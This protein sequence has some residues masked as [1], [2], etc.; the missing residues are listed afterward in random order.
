[1]LYED[2]KHC[3]LKLIKTGSKQ[4][5]NFRKSPKL[6]LFTR[7]FPRQE[8]ISSKAWGDTL[9]DKLGSLEDSQTS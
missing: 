1:M 6:T 9:L 8:Y 7:P 3:I 2:G 5:N 4:R